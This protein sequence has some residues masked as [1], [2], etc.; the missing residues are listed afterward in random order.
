MHFRTGKHHN[1]SQL[2]LG[3]TDTLCAVST[4]VG[5]R[6]KALGY[7]HQLGI[8]LLCKVKLIDGDILHDETQANGPASEHIKVDIGRLAGSGLRAVL[9]RGEDRSAS[10][11]E[12][13][14][15]KTQRLQCGPVGV[16]AGR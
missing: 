4:V 11:R 6:P 8:S 1:L 12:Y 15:L 5:S 10:R 9:G 3:Q 2:I 7:T 13:A 14:Q 16:S